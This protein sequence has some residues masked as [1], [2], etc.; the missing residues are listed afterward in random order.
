MNKNKFQF[1]D[2]YLIDELLSEEHGL[3]RYTIRLWVDLRILP[4]IE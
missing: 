1:P 3:I 2:H 4:G